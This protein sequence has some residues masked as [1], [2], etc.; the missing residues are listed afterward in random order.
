MTSISS[1]VS[2]L[3]TQVTVLQVTQGQR[4]LRHTDGVEER[5]PDGPE[6]LSWS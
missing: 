6:H 5:V 4:T 2:R 3:S 1:P